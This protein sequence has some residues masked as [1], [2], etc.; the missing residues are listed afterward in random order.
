MGFVT[1]NPKYRAYLDHQGFTEPDR[2]LALPGVIAT[3][4]PQRHVLQ[5]T[6][7]NGPSA[8]AVFLK[9][10]HRVSWK[11]R[12]ASAWAGFGLVS[13]SCREAATL[14]AL[15]RMDVDCPEW[16]AAGEDDSG[17]AF[18]LLRAARDGVDLRHFLQQPLPPAE[19]RRWARLLG[20]ALARLHA[21][22]FNHPDL[23]SKHVLVHPGDGRFTFM[24]WQRS[25]KWHRPSW[26]R[27]GRDLAALNATLSDELVSPRDRGM[28]FRAYCRVSG[29]FDRRMQRRVGRFI[30]EQ[31]ERL[32]QR[33]RVRELRQPP[34]RTG[35]QSLIWL[36]GEA[37]CV[38]PEF[39]ALLQGQIPPWLKPAGRLEES[40]PPA[41]DSR[42][43]LGR[44]TRSIVPL[45]DGRSARLVCR[46]ANRARN[47]LKTLLRCR[48][49]PSPELEQV[50][51][52]YRLQRYGIATPKL[53]A[54]G[55][56]TLRG[57]TESFLLTDPLPQGVGLLDWL[58]DQAGQPHR[59]AERRQRWRLIRE[60]ATVL[61]V[62]HTAGYR[63]HSASSDPGAQLC[64]Y[65]TDAG[66]MKV[67]LSHVEGWHRCGPSAPASRDLVRLFEIL[68]PGL[69]SRAEALRFLL[70]YLGQRRLTAATKRTARLILSRTRSPQQ[71]TLWTSPC[72]MRA[73][74]PPAAV[75]RHT[76]P[77]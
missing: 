49:A 73:S 58:A 46:Q 32:L 68:R 75:A 22:G 61:Q 11:D 18:L 74:C 27:R 23:Y 77:I 25:R 29:W 43:P 52:L 51:L 36:E 47:R 17:Q 37:L 5:L 21:A 39:H 59:P 6:L 42:K 70:A 8:L 65:R 4:H 40:F 71:V 13:K 7:G 15:A 66:G 16:I 10:E 9:K 14:Q 30:L 64:I 38:T 55:Q 54:F 72:A 1:I 19:R 31:S 28:C 48:P 67:G 35:A 44:V 69:R 60:A 24:D 56:H 34:L 63:L 26:R 2:F 45:P 76:L 53:L 3:G 33:S 41:A 50:G 57:R 20:E 12:L 62:I